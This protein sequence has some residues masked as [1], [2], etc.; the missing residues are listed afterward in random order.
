MSQNLGSPSGENGKSNI[1]NKKKFIVKLSE[2][3]HSDPV[4]LLTVTINVP[5]DST[6]F[7]K[8]IP[9]TYIGYIKGAEEIYGR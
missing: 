4:L 6:D 8:E 1:R 9:I 7:F 2:I 3:P 5:K